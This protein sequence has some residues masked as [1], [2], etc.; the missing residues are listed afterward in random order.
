MPENDA[1]AT[2]LEALLE[3]TRAIRD[4]KIQVESLKSMMF[5]HRPAFVPTFEEQVKKVTESGKLER[6]DGLMASLESV[7]RKLREK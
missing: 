3:Q 7:V 5:E 6:L 1:I 2:I 4:V